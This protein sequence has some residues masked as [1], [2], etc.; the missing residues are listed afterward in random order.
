VWRKA[1]GGPNKKHRQYGTTGAA[2]CSYAN[3]RVRI[4]NN[5]TMGLAAGKFAPDQPWNDQSGRAVTRSIG[6]FNDDFST[7]VRRSPEH[8]MGAPRLV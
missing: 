3:R 2:I 8:L 4:R 7:P 5:E 6:D 1:Q